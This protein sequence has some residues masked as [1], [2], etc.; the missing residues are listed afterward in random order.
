MSDVVIH[1]LGHVG[2]P[3]AAAMA[4][5]H[6]VWG[7]DPRGEAVLD[8]I[9]QEPGL[10]EAVAG[11]RLGAPP[12]P[13]DVAVVAV[14][15]PLKNMQA[16]LTAVAS[17]T[18][19]ALQNLRAGGL[20]LLAST[21]PVGTARSLEVPEGVAVA[22]L[23]ERG[24]PG[25]ML[26]EVIGAARLVGGVGEE[27]MERARAFVETWCDGAVIGVEAEEAELAKLVENSW[28]DLSI[29]FVNEL[30]TACRGLGLH[31]ARI[32]QLASSHP[33]VDLPVPG[34]GVGGHCLPVDPHFLPPGMVLPRMARRIND[35]R[36]DE[37]VARIRAVAHGTTGVLGLAY[38]PGVGDARNSPAV[39]I[40]Q[41]L[42]AMGIEVLA[43]DPYVGDV[44][45]PRGELDE[46]LRCDVV[47][48]LVDHVAYAAFRVDLDLAR[49]GG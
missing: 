33:R 17:A 22:S 35:G 2:L 38:K 1:G 9:D 43:H 6:T 30:E 32:A 41:K 28:R 36:V 42:W 7:V 24:L 19:D 11:I 39:A 20:L 47:V 18:Q 23:P 14:P 31:G 5:A 25:Q 4:R 37:M 45:V 15:T 8:G 3:L 49:S 44:G 26:A 13:V 21:C 40:V 46:V 34:I 10:A 48:R 16:D 12:A 29:A 27:A